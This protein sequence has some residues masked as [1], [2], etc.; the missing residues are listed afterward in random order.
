[1]QKSDKLMTLKIN[2]DLH[3]WLKDYAERENT[4]MSRIIKAHLESLRRKDRRRQR[5]AGRK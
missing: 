1:M 2:S 5:K 4:K 3:S